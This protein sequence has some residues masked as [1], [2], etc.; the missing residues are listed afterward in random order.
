MAKVER[1]ETVWKIAGGYLI[2]CVSPLE[3]VSSDI[4]ALFWLLATPQIEAY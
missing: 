3:R 2:A 1:G 4:F